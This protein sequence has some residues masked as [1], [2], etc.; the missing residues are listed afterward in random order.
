MSGSSFDLEFVS[1]GSSFGRLSLS[2][3]RAT[4]SLDFPPLVAACLAFVAASIDFDLFDERARECGMRVRLLATSVEDE[5]EDMQATLLL[6]CFFDF[7]FVD[8]LTPEL[9]VGVVVVDVGCC[10]TGA[11]MTEVESG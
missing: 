11:L 3:L 6:M 5:D 1:I 9:A 10:W 4:E 8:L 7:D 2:G